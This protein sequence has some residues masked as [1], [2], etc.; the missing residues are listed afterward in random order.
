MS[1]FILNVGQASPSTKVRTA[2]GT[3]PERGGW[4]GNGEEI[5]HLGSSATQTSSQEK[6]KE[7]N[8][9]QLVLEPPAPPA[10]TVSKP[11]SSNN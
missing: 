3:H 4:V 7:E 6:R 11:G 8:Q 10:V 1:E 2:E 5:T 9:W